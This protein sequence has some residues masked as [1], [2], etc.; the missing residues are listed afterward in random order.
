VCFAWVLGLRNGGRQS[1]RAYLSRRKTWLFVLEG[2]S[3]EAARYCVAEI[4]RTGFEGTG[5]REIARRSRSS[6]ACDIG[7]EYANVQMMCL[8]RTP[9]VSR[10]NSRS[11]SA[12]GLPADI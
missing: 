7:C 5:K 8:L 11:G 9:E 6:R 12:G 2:N 3:C 10:R 4:W 1:E